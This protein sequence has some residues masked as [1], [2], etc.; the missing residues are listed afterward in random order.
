MEII[1]QILE[2]WDLVALIIAMNLALGGLSQV[3]RWISTKTQATWDDD[4][5]KKLSSASEFVAKIIDWL[6]GNAQHKNP[7][8]P[9]K[10]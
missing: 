1:K 5:A 10:Q 9:P 2:R 6:H 3:F 8:S 4:L 7:E